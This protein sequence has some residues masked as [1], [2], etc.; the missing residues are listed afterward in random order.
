[1]LA[2]DINPENLKKIFLSTYE[3]QPDNFEKLLGM[4]GVGPK[5]IRALALISEL[6]YQTPYAIRDPATYSFAHGGKDGIP[7]PVNKKTYDD[8]IIFLHDAV[9]KAKLGYF[10]KIHALQRLSQIW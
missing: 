10:E 9:K 1:M 6:V 7:Y 5:T 3:R 8:S 4:G 2:C